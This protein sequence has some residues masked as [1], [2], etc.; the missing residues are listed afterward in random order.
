MRR[1]ALAALVVLLL[2]P[3]AGAGVTRLEITRRE[4][5]AGGQAFGTAGAY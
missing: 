4:P 2:A 5:F 3:A 1:L